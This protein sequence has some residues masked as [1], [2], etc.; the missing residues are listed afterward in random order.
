MPSTPYG[1]QL[2]G[3]ELRVVRISPGQWGDPVV[4]N[5]ITCELSLASIFC[6]Y[7]ALSYV[8]GAGS[9]TDTI[10]LEEFQFHVTLNLLCA[11]R[12]LRKTDEAILLWV[13]ALVS[14]DTIGPVPFP[15]PYAHNQ[16]VYQP[17][18]QNRAE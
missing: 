4:A 12:H 13:D 5:L 1:S 14:S 11:L 7:T 18:K 9:V 2:G 3:Y 6:P 16:P 10:Y 17:K 8:W 15:F